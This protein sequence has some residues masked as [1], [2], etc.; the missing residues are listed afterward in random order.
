MSYVALKPKLLGFL[1]FLLDPNLQVN[2]ELGRTLALVSSKSSKLNVRCSLGEA[3]W[4][5]REDMLSSSCLFKFW[6]LF[7][8]GRQD[9]P[10]H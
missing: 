4:P 5:H 10:V 7:C 9:S 2:T 1:S 6:I 3:S 8:N